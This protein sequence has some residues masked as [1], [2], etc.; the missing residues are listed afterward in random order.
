MFA[1]ATACKPE[2]LLR[3]AVTPSTGSGF[4]V[5][6]PRRAR[7]PRPG[8]A[9]LREIARYQRSTHLLIPRAPFLRIVRGIALNLAPDMRF[10]HSAVEAL[11]EATEAYLV[12]WLSTANVAATHTGRITVSVSDF[13]LMRRIRGHTPM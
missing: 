10:Q 7:A 11:R 12:E 1:N 13:D 8:T 3:P 4:G 2:P 5:S 6:R 9:I